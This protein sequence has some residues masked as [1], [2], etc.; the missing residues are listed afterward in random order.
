MPGVEGL[1]DT[2][3]GLLEGLD[4]GKIFR[5]NLREVKLSEVTVEGLN[6]GSLIKN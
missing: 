4:L 3:H 2:M 5:M 6:L 1:D